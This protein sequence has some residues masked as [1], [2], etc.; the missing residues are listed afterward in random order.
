LEYLERTL[1]VACQEL[2]LPFNTL[3]SSSLAI[4]PD[5]KGAARILEICARLEAKRYV[6]S[7]GG[8]DLYDPAGFAAAGVELRFLAP[9]RGSELSIVQ[10]LHDESPTA[11][12]SEIRHQLELEP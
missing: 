12:A 1:R 6:N 9:H 8:R 3:R 5:L 7:P 2:G 10:R 11:L 4:A